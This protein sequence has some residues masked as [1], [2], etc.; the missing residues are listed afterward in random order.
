LRPL[1]YRRQKSPFA[2]MTGA[3]AATVGGILLAAAPLAPLEP[4]AWPLAE[5]AL[6]LVVAAA[7]VGGSV[8]PWRPDHVVD[9][10]GSYAV[11]GAV[12]ASLALLL[13]QLAAGASSLGLPE[14]LAAAIAANASVAAAIAVAGM[15][16]P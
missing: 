1:R 14:A 10:I 11:V 15:T 8:V 9:Q 16:E 3:A 6:A 5:T 2:E 7:I 12:T 13:S 4:G